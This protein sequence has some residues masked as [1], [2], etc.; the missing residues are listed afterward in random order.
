[1]SNSRAELGFTSCPK[2]WT[3]GLQDPLQRASDRISVT[4]NVLE[5]PRVKT[6]FGNVPDP[7]GLETCGTQLLGPITAD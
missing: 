2:P 7:V 5:R 4:R 1:M 3:A 6:V